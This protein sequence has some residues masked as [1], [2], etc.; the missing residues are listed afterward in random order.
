MNLDWKDRRVRGAVFVAMHLAALATI[1]EFVVLPIREFFADRDARIADQRIQLARFEGIASQAAN[2]GGMA[3][4]VDPEAQKGEFLVGPSDGL[5]GAELQARLKGF[6]ESAGAHVRSAQNL[7]AKAVGQIKF[8]G[9][10]VEIYGNIQALRKAIHGI[11][12]ARPYLFITSANMKLALSAGRPNSAEE[13]AIQAQLD[14]FVPMQ[15]EGR[16]P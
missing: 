12:G 8:S 11:E 2:V 10:R 1:A 5:I 16:S 13:P 15:I 3:H 7:P 6:T 9:S 14:V 4:Q